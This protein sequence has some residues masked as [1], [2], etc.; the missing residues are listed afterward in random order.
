MSLWIS[1]IGFPF[2]ETLLTGK[3]LPG[4][5]TV[6][7]KNLGWNK[8]ALI[9]WA[10]QCGLAGKRHY[11]VSAAEARAGSLCH[12]MIDHHI[13]GASLSTAGYDGEV[14]EK[15]QTKRRDVR[16]QSPLERRRAAVSL[17]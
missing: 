6:I 12:A 16:S 3:R 9:G 1:H 5:T 17:I 10:N 7:P 13:K 15:A 2:P 14:V 11:D 4:V 8:Q